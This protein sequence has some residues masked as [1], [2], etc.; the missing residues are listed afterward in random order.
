MS[1]KS[2]NSNPWNVPRNADERIARA[3]YERL[4]Y[5]HGRWDT[6]VVC[7]NGTPPYEG[8]KAFALWHR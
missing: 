1:A 6:D 5:H 4:F 3:L 7:V 8:G 2:V